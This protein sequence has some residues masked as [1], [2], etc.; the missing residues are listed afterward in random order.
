MPKPIPATPENISIGMQ[1]DED[2]AVADCGCTL[3]RSG[4]TNDDPLFV[5]CPLHLQAAFMQEALRD[6][7]KA[8]DELMTEFMS[9]KRAA[10]WGIINDAMVAAEKC[11]RTSKSTLGIPS[12]KSM[13]KMKRG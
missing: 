12:T 4:K 9:K 1:P 10:N 7:L 2:V 13:S 3:Y 8:A 6:M 5:F 11:L